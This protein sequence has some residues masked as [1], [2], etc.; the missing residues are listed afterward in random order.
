MTS[1]TASNVAWAPMT[2]EI[3]LEALTFVFTDL[4]VLRGVYEQFT[5]GFEVLGLVEARGVLLELDAQLG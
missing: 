1:T 3:S 5:E 4:E 2:G